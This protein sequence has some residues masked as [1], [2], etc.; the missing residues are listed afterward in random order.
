MGILF[1]IIGIIV[2]A[3]FIWLALSL[4]GLIFQVL[5]VVFAIALIVWLI[6]FIIRRI[7]NT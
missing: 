4:G 3:I 6:T 5:A 1:A 7:K 2:V